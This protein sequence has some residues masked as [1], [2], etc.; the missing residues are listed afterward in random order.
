[1]YMT[2][3][4]ARRLLRLRT[5][6]VFLMTGLAL[7]PGIFGQTS[8]PDPS[9]PH[10][11]HL[12]L[13]DGSYQIVTSYRVQGGNV[14][15]LSAERGGTQEIIPLSL[16]DLDA[17]RAWEQQHIPGSHPEA[18]PKID[19]DLL[20]E[21]A[22]RAALTPEVAPD[23]DLPEQDSV[24]AL[25]TFQGTPELV[26]LAQ[27][28]GELNHNTAHNVLKAAIN[29]HSSAHQIAE[30]K[31]LRSA[32]QLHIP[33]PVL[34]IRIGEN[35]LTGGGGT[36][37]V[38]TQGASGNAPTASPG[39]SAYSCYVIVRADVRTDS[40]IIASFSLSLLGTPRRQEDI[41]ETNTETLPG[42]HW[43]KLTPKDP[44]SFGEYA[45]MEVISDREVNLG[46]WD[47]GIHPVA[48]ENRDAIKPQPKRPFRLDHRRPE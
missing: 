45:L 39:G 9:V 48:P 47:F 31:G 23:L 29:P 43:I 27:S 32:A 21:E 4:P 44:L 11:I 3:Q 26:P 18:T 1:M 41:V 12:I 20:K 10:R 13:K 35:S 25:D 16:V 28:E 38:D 33:D 17:T 15:Y 42:G 34:Y 40:R 19:P 37:T 8:T 14:L 5:L 6:A 36:F 22:D 7:S 2:S 46:V 24:L 30:L